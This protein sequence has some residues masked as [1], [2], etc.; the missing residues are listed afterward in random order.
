MRYFSSY[1]DNIIARCL[2]PICNIS[3]RDFIKNSVNPRWWCEAVD[4][5]PRCYHWTYYFHDIFSFHPTV[6]SGISEK[7]LTDKLRIKHTKL[8]CPNTPNSCFLPLQLQRFLWTFLLADL[9]AKFNALFAQLWI[10]PVMLEIALTLQFEMHF[11][12]NRKNQND[13]K[14]CIRSTSAQYCTIC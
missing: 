12:G 8:S 4:R 14:C 6:P 11:H 13:Y 9:D 7:I 3:S 5:F 1:M 10:D 2:L